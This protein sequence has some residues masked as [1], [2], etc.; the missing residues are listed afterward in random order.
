MNRPQLID[1]AC[2]HLEE[3]RPT[4][5]LRL[6][7]VYGLGLGEVIAELVN[8]SKPSITFEATFEVD[9]YE[10]CMECKWMQSPDDPVH[11]IRCSQHPEQQA[12]ARA[13]AGR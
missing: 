13:E 6:M 12:R 1:Q 11:W 3:G 8:R 9:G 2:K 4:E 5:G 7:N 10:R